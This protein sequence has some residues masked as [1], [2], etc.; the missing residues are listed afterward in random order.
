MTDFQSPRDRATSGPFATDNPY[1]LRRI[2]PLL[3]WWHLPP[4]L[5]AAVLGYIVAWGFAFT[6][7]LA[8]GRLLAE[9]GS[10]F[11]APQWIDLVVKPVSSDVAHIASA[12]GPLIV[13]WIMVPGRVQMTGKDGVGLAFD[14]PGWSSLG[15]LVGLALGAAAAGTML[16]LVQGHTGAEL[17]SPFAPYNTVQ[18]GALQ[19][20]LLFL[21][22]VIVAPLVEEL[23]FRGFF[24]GCLRGACG[25]ILAAVIVSVAF[26]LI[27]RPDTWL[28]VAALTAVAVGTAWLRLRTGS[29]SAPMA[30]HAG[31]NFAVLLLTTFAV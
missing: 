14:Q 18:Y 29:L 30:L 24:L 2:P 16:F 13:A 11:T 20:G 12:I 6:T 17:Y 4:I 25:A 10:G 19:F 27:H 15:L 21:S 8:I 5:V 31:Y 28:H 23:L 3:K 7:L 1:K 9:A 26:V 22:L